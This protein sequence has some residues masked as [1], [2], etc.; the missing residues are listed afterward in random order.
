MSVP[1][2]LNYLLLEDGFKLTLEDITTPGS[3]L[4]ES[5]VVPEIAGTDDLM[6]PVDL[7]LPEV[8]DP[9][10]LGDKDK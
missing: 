7:V 1:P 9:K 5:S 8:G 3:L 2:V 6:L 10:E 4:L